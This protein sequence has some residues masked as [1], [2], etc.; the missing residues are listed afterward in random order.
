MKGHGMNN[1]TEGP[2]LVTCLTEEGTHLPLNRD[3]SLIA[4]D[5]VLTP[6]NDDA[7]KATDNVGLSAGIKLIEHCDSG[8]DVHAETTLMDRRDLAGIL[9]TREGKEV[10]LVPAQLKMPLNPLGQIT[11][12]PLFEPQWSRRFFRQFFHKRRMKLFN[13]YNRP[14]FKKRLRSLS[15][16][17]YL[18]WKLRRLLRFLQMCRLTR[19]AL[20]IL[21]LRAIFWNSWRQHSRRHQPAPS[22]ADAA[23]SSGAADTGLITVLAILC[24][25]F[26]QVCWD[27]AL[28]HLKAQ[29]W[30]IVLG[31][32][33]LASAASEGGVCSGFFMDTDVALSNAMGSPS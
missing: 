22:G 2:S 5:T 21:A 3:E 4:A 15:N 31:C 14:Q 10:E 26:V 29:G 25:L 32:G 6:L 19:W 17:G 27:M 12:P 20:R 24:L 18:R 23:R 11:Q 28:G 8:R 16:H 33:Y 30:N 1:I 9:S 13:L 7:V